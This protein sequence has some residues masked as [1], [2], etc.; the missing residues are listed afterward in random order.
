M[1][2]RRDKYLSAKPVRELPQQI[3]KKKKRQTARGKTKAR[4]RDDVSEPR[5]TE[6]GV[7]GIG[8]EP[9]AYLFWEI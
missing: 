1:K 8:I 3:S 9:L 5:R 7:V 4:Q 6:E 2:V